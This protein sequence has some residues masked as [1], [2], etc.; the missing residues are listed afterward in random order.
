MLRNFENN[1]FNQIKLEQCPY[2][3]PHSMEISSEQ[4]NDKEVEKNSVIIKGLQMEKTKFESSKE[5]DLNKSKS[6]DNKTFGYILR[7]SIFKPET[8]VFKTF[9]W[10]CPNYL[11]IAYKIKRL[12]SISNRKFFQKDREIQNL[13][14][15]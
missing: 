14:S 9:F 8:K 3:M 13:Y 15:I 4:E 5:M 12:Y 6:N 11:I 2:K 7:N 10:T 1:H